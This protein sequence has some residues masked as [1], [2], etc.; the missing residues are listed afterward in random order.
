MARGAKRRKGGVSPAAMGLMRSAASVR[1]IQYQSFLAPLQDVG[2]GQTNPLIDTYIVNLD[3]KEPILGFMESVFAVLRIDL[4]FPSSA[5]VIKLRQLVEL[6]DECFKESIGVTRAAFSKAKK[7][8]KNI[9]KYMENMYFYDSNLTEKRIYLAN[10][11]ID[12]GDGMGFDLGSMLRD[13]TF[14]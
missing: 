9:A 6:A 3:A 7:M 1:D 13:S 14:Y 8:L 11:M 12:F 5:T 10:F 4:S 2:P